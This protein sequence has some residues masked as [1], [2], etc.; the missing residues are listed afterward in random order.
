M[1]AIF[2]FQA[3]EVRISKNKE[4]SFL[5]QGK[6]QSQ[7]CGRWWRW[8]FVW[9]NSYLTQTSCQQ[10]LRPFLRAPGPE[11][12]QGGLFSLLMSSVNAAMSC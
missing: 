3:A 6:N 2:S 4:K 11:P 9:F 1:N 10:E 8:V 7:L 5:S 12:S